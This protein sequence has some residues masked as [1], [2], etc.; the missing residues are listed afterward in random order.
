MVAGADHRDAA[1]DLLPRLAG[2]VGARASRLAAAPPVPSGAAPEAV[3]AP[4]LVGEL[5]ETPGFDY[6]AH[7]EAVLAHGTP[8]VKWVRRILWEG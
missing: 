8:P 5:G 4:R 3:P 1:L 2:D 6:R 7:L